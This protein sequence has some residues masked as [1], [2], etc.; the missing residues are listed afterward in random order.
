MRYLE[1]FHHRL[2]QLRDNRGLSLQDIA[3]ICGVDSDRVAAWEAREERQRSYPGVSELMD[4]AVQTGTALEELLDL[5]DAHNHGQLELPGLTFSNDE[6][7]SSAL[8]ELEEEISR[9]QLSSEEVE[10][11]RRFRKTSTENR[12]MVLQIMG[13]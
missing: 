3:Q 8:K 6:G 12:R 9:L 1:T 10:L 5:D 4:L 13:R 11:L 7:L 2:R